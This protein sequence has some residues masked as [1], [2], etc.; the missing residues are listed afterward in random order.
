[1]LGV[2][3]RPRA[4]TTVAP[5]PSVHEQV[6]DGTEQ[7][8]RVWQRAEN[9]GFVLAPKKEERDRREE[10]EADYPWNVEGL[11]PGPGVNSHVLALVSSSLSIHRCLRLQQLSCPR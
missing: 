9:V 11:P 10:A 2:A 6:D 1:M 3:L 5:V 7:K 8:Q 4:A